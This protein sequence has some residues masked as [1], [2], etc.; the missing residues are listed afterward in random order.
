MAPSRGNMRLMNRLDFSVDQAGTDGSYRI[1][2]ILGL[3]PPGFFPICLT[4]HSTPLT[5]SQNIGLNFLFPKWGPNGQLFI[6]ELAL[7]GTNLY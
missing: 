5:V 1:T 3:V 6:V 4:Q 7:L 2:S